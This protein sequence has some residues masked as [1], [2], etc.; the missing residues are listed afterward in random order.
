MSSAKELLAAEFEAMRAEIVAAYETSGIISSGSW[1]AGV[2]VI[3]LPN[4]FT[5]AAPDYINGRQPGKQPPSEAIEQWL[6]AKGIA[7]GLEKDIGI[8]SLAYLIARKI[9]KEGWQ[10]RQQNLIDTIITPQRIQQLLD[11]V[12]NT[13]L[14]DFTAQLTAHLKTIAA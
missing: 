3:E 5:I 2:Q 4:G 12:Q 10:P 6:K 13:A 11:K 7:A 1:G 9:G 14:A 8:S